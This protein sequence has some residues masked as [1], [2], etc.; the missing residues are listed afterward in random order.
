LGVLTDSVCKQRM[1]EKEQSRNF[2]L[3][4]I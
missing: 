3:L 4:I 2:F 1:E